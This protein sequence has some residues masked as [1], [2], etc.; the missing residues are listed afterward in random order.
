MVSL[1]R[2]EPV[3]GSGRAESQSP[4]DAVVS[5]HDAVMLFQGMRAAAGLESSGADLF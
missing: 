4:D 5:R 1:S 3:D 2:R